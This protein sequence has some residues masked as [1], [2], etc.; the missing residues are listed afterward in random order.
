MLDWR[1]EDL[2]PQGADVISARALAPLDVLLG[3]AEK[4]RRPAGIGLFPKG[5]TVHNEI[6]DAKIR[7]RFEQ[8]LH[9]SQTDAR[10][11]IVQIGAINRG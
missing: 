8:E 10:G 9:P 11:A 1:V 3:H 5:G 4:H 7:W 2:P 6:A